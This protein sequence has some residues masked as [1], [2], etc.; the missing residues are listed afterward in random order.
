MSTIQEKIVPKMHKHD[1]KKKMINLM[2]SEA[3]F[4]NHGKLTN[5]KYFQGKHTILLMLHLLYEI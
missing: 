1:L 3:E 4:E 2:L 5:P